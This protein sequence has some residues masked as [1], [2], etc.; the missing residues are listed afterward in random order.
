MHARPSVPVGGARLD[1]SAR[2]IARVLVTLLTVAIAA[3]TS[4]VS[5]ASPASALTVSVSGSP[6]VLHFADKLAGK[7][8]CTYVSGVGCVGYTPMIAGT[9]STAYRSPAYAGRQIVTI[10]YQLWV[11]QNGTWVRYAGIQ[12]RQGDI[13]TGYSAVNLS[14]INMS[15]PV[16]YVSASTPE[17]PGGALTPCSAS[18][19]H[20]S[21]T[22]A[23]TTYAAPP[24]FDAQ[25]GPDGC[26]PIEIPQASPPKPREAAAAMR[27]CG[28]RSA[29]WS[30]F[31]TN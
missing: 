26:G 29:Q 9:G 12:R 14:G 17:S 4:M 5:I 20:P 22:T 8:Y 28:D 3:L 13:P 30:V 11:P 1:P 21:P 23:T 25:Q 7:D 10:D 27:G 2:R 24:A 19:A 6:G 31:P 18:A 16:G 15:A